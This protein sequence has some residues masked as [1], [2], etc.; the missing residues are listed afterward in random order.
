[1]RVDKEKILAILEIYY[2]NHVTMEQ[3]QVITGMTASGLQRIFNSKEAI[4]YR[5]AR[6]L[7]IE[8]AE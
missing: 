4:H 7:P 1:M 5:I 2:Q 6:Q 3:L 8:F